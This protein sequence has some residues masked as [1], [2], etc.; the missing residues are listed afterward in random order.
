MTKAKECLTFAFYVKHLFK[1]T[2]EKYKDKNK[3]RIF[4]KRNKRLKI[5]KKLMNYII[6]KIYKKRKNH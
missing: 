1:I 2:K 6:N 3:N 4:R 5:S